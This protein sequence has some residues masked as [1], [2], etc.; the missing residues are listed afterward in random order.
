MN[1]RLLCAALA[2]SF[3]TTVASQD[4]VAVKAGKLLTISGPVLENQIVVIENGRITAIAAADGFEIPWTAKVIDASD[5]VV[6]P[7]WVIAHSDGGMGHGGNNESMQ[8]VSWLSVADAVDPAAEYFEDALRAGVGTIHVMPGNNTLLGGSGL[9]LRPF[10]RTVED[11]TMSANT[12]IKMSLQN[13]RG[14][15]LQQIREL[16]RALADTRDYMA[17]FERRKK[18]FEQEQEAGAI[19]ADKKWTEEYD[20]TKKAAIAL[21]EKKSKGWLYVPTAAEV[22]EALRLSQ[23]LDLQIVLGQNIDEGIAMVQRFGKPVVLDDQIEYYEEDEETKQQKKICTARMLADGGTTFALTLGSNGP[24]SYPWWQL[25]T[26]VRNGVDRRTALEALTIVPATI[27]GLED[28]IG[29]VAVGK[30]GNLQIL[31]GDPMQATTWVDTVL[32]EG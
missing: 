10:G 13:Q 29:T 18:E 19:P 6:L 15:R 31:T 14:G 28:Q 25:G 22:P 12:G 8:N 2:A 23:E 32:L 21:I 30:L 1:S 16:R 27:L 20:R 17:D 11:M 3:A 7:T 5:K 24:T 26:C 4:V 9:V